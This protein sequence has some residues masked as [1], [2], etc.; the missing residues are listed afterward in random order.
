MNTAANA[1]PRP[2]VLITGAAKRVGATIARGLHAAGYDLALHYRHS[3]TEMDSLCTELEA[4]RKNST[5]AIQAELADIEKL[6]AIIIACIARYGRLD[7]VLVNNAS[8]FFPT[9]V[10]AT[11]VQQWNELFASNAQAPFFLAQAAA[12]HLKSAKGSIVSIVDIY[13]E[14]PLARHPVYSMAKAGLAM[15]TQ[16]LAKE[17]APEV[18]VNAVAPGAILWPESGKPY[19]D[20]QELVARTALKRTG[21]PEDVAT[22]VLFLLARCEIHDGTNSERRWRWSHACDLARNS[23]TA[24]VRVRPACRAPHARP[25]AARVFYRA[26]DAPP[27]ARYRRAA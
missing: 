11:T 20:Q 15:M 27:A 4:A 8:A 9:A 14:R 12:P 10:G 6:P 23:T 16:A 13:A 22:A 3:R 2:V 7:G 26:R 21:T 17:L 19:A 24:W 25:T 5:C 18:R 1:S